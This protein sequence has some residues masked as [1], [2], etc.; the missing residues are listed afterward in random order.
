MYP[1]YPKSAKAALALPNVDMD[2]RKQ[3]D[4]SVTPVKRS[5]ADRATEIFWKKLG[6]SLRGRVFVMNLSLKFT[7]LKTKRLKNDCG[8]FNHVFFV[9]CL[10]VMH[11]NR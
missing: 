8:S 5:K 7:T 3:S 11:Q 6:I 10:F 1:S 4:D 2:L 9:I